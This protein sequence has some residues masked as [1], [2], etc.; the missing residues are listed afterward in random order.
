MTTTDIK[1]ADFIAPVPLMRVGHVAAVAVGNALEFYDFLTYSFFAAQ[2]GRT[3]FPSNDP[4]TSL[5]ASLATFGAGFLMR[6]VGA[7]VIGRFGDRTGRKPAMLL[8][9]TLMGLAMIGLA[10]TPAYRTIGIAG[11]VLAIIF[12]LIQ[13][14]ALGGEVGPN[15]AY[16]VEAAPPRRRGLYVSLQMMSQ[17]ASILVSGLVGFGLASVLSDR[18]LD[19]WGWRVAFL[20]G[21]VIVPFGLILRRQL[22]ETLHAPA[23]VGGAR[24]VP[25]VPLGMLTALG[26]VLLAGGTVVSYTQNYLTIYA[27]SFLHMPTRIG[28]LSTIAVGLFS[29]A[30]NPVGGWLS[31][32]F[33]RKPV[34]IAPWLV[35]LAVGIPGFWFLSH[36]RTATA[37]VALTAVIAVCGSLAA[38]SVLVA[39]TEGLPAKIRCGALGLIYAFSIS[40]FGGSTQFVVA[41][42][43]RITGSP[44]APAWYMTGA[45]TIALIAMA[46]LPESAPCKVG[47][48]AGF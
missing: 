22:V 37:L 14:F 2:I 17:G 7:L 31:D 8:T 11:P 10:L 27:T 25:G 3:F 42:L 20:L 47:R 40:I 33:G 32:R 18:A 13:G 44:L 48:R 6:P 5:L 28:F 24:D 1:A 34:M 39:V 38:S 43:T 9:F 19:D 41:W 45:V 12:R 16:L 21:A 36:H 15:T 35:L 4:S 46:R 30:A 23:T 26:I 29:V